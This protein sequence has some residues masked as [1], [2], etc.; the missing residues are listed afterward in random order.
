MRKFEA[1]EVAVT[2]IEIFDIIA[3]SSGIATP[4]TPGEFVPPEQG[5]NQTPYG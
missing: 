4:T 1:P 2:T 5:G 3:T